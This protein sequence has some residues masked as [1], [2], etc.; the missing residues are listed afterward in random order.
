MFS[1]LT[2]DIIV[3]VSYF[4]ANQNAS[5]ERRWSQRYSRAIKLHVQLVAFSLAE[6]LLVEKPT[7]ICQKMKT[8]QKEKK[9]TTTN[10]A[11]RLFSLPANIRN[12]LLSS[13]WMSLITLEATQE[14][15][16]GAS[17]PVLEDSIKDVGT[18]SSL[19][20][21]GKFVDRLDVRDFCN[22][23]LC[24]RSVTV[25]SQNIFITKTSLSKRE[26]FS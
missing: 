2:S 4:L 8:K 10:G 21:S 6:K 11:P 9:K 5:C 17:L 23:S 13:F 20:C 15:R 25:N 7:N 14:T 26:W 3:L 19:H 22:Y 1:L 18:T 12:S 16:N 24:F